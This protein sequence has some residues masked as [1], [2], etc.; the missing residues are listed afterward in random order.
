MRSGYPTRDY[1][2]TDPERVRITNYEIKHRNTHVCTRHGK[3]SSDSFEQQHVTQSKN[4]KPGRNHLQIFPRI[5]RY[6]QG[7]SPQWYYAEKPEIMAVGEASRTVYATPDLTH[8]VSIDFGASGCGIAMAIMRHLSMS[9]PTLDR[10]WDWCLWWG[11]ANAILQ[12]PH[13]WGPLR[14]TN[15]LLIRISLADSRLKF[16]KLSIVY[17]NRIF[18]ARSN[19]TWTL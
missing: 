7:N 17:F 18:Y 5:S 10:G 9:S 14:V 12:I 4:G 19:P 16:A 1:E 8:Y 2:R 11:F 3:T 6:L 15:P 13:P